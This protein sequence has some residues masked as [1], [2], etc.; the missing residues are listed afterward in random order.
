MTDSTLAAR[1]V[2]RA[3]PTV[4]AAALTEGVREHV[5][6]DSSGHDIDHARRVFL[7]GTRLAEA[8]GPTSRSSRPRR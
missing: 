6:D 2:D 3:A 7:L 5:A 4:D 1:V 8:A